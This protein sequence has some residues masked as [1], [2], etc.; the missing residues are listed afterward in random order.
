[1]PAP[2]MHTGWRKLNDG[3]GEGGRLDVSKPLA[4]QLGQRRVGGRRPVPAQTGQVTRKEE[5][6][7]E[8][9]VSDDDD[10]LLRIFA[11]S[12]EKERG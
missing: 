7:R 9:V 10:G 8:V 12:E 3:G 1:M 2:I 6:T 5:A 4:L 11:E